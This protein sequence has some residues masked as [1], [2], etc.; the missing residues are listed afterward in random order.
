MKTNKAT[1]YPLV[2]C[3]DCKFY[4]AT[5]H[6]TLKYCTGINMVQPVVEFRTCLIKQ[7]ISK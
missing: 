7:K 3:D 4:K 6:P 2:R 5:D 1:T